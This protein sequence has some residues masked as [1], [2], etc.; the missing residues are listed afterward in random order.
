[1]PW[2]PSEEREIIGSLPAEALQIGQA[3]AD[4]FRNRSANQIAAELCG[5]M[6]ARFQGQLVIF[7]L[8]NDKLTA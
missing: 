1:M 6:G 7:D 4:Q 5:L 8:K 3:Y 2:T